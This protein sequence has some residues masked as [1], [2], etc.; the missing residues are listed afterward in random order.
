[1]DSFLDEQ[2]AI[3][4]SEPEPN[5]YNVQHDYSLA[6]ALAQCLIH[7]NEPYLVA[8]LGDTAI[9]LPMLA[10]IYHHVAQGQLGDRP[11]MAAFCC[12]CNAGALFDPRYQD[13]VY[14]FAAQGYYEVMVLLADQQT[15]SYWNHLTGSCIHGPMAGAALE[16]LN[17]LTSMRAI[18]AL[19]AYPN[20]R[21]AVMDGMTD[22]EMTTAERWNRVYRLPDEPNYGEELLDTIATEDP[23]LP[24]HDMGLGVWTATT[25]R[26]YPI[27]RLYEQHNVIF[28]QVDGR[29]IVIIFNQEVGLPAIFYFDTDHVEIRGDEFI[30]NSHARYRQ[31][32]LY[33]DD[34]PIK[35][36]RPNHNMIRWYAFASIFPD[37]DIYG[38]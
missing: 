5:P 10:M 13:R 3:L 17:T 18:D 29:R 1:M 24:R 30:L 33:I 9:L 37:C 14:T 2:R 8:P 15:Q 20:A 7:P 38:G 12:L 23:R 31:G 16:R 32:R 21:I 26:Y 11:W 4:L 28:D 22:E 27:L 35:P 6:E 19:A 25:R 36:E 34:Q